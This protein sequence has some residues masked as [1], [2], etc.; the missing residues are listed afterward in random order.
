VQLL[1][2]VA[3]HDDLYV[4]I[5]LERERYDDMLLVRAN[6]GGS[7]ALLVGIVKVNGCNVL[8]IRASDFTI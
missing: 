6:Y 4:A 5:F 2:C 3:R 7:A 1:C 8:H